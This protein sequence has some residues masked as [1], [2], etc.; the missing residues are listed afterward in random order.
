HR[1]GDLGPQGA[2][3]RRPPPDQAGVAVRVR[4]RAA[5]HGGN[6]L[7]A[8]AGGEHGVDGA[9]LGRV[10]P[11][12][13]SGGPQAVG[14]GG[15]RSR[16]AHQRQ[17][18]TAGAGGVVSPA[19]EYA[20]VAAGG[21]RLAV[22]A[23]GSGQRGVQQPRPGAGAVGRAVQALHG[24]PRNHPRSSRP[25]LGRSTEPIKF[26]AIWYET[27]PGKGNAMAFVE[28]NPDYRE[29]LARH[30]LTA[31]E[32]FL[33]LPGVVI[34]GHPDRNVTRVTIGTGPLALPAFLKREHHVR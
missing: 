10:G 26:K 5:G 22:A 2:A 4:L 27:A 33:Q 15:G 14:A 20:G 13:G 1:A 19:G 31:P 30:G 17:A 32:Q 24:A 6:L 11:V 12:G 7:A 34:T 28:I 21:V 9:G 18:D 25:R 29:T 16:L 8:L 23:G 3:A